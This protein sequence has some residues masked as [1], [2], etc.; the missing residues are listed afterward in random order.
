MFIEDVPCAV[1]NAEE[2]G[3]HAEALCSASR[4]APRLAEIVRSYRG[5]I[6]QILM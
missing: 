6:I 1:G 4:R 2:E 3:S 5:V